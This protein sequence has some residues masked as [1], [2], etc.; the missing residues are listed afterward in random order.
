VGRERYGKCALQVGRISLG[1]STKH[2]LH[3]LRIFT[4]TKFNSAMKCLA[5]NSVLSLQIPCLLC[6]VHKSWS[7]PLGGI[8]STNPTKQKWF[9]IPYSRALVFNLGYTKTFYINQN[10]IQEPLEPWTSSDPRTHED[11]SQN[12]RAGMPETRSITSLTGQKKINIW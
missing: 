9:M 6:A 1:S 11:S 7:N 3:T 8:F 5:L 10:E 12:W 2:V 4:P